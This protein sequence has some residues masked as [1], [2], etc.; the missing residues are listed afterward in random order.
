MGKKRNVTKKSNQNTRD[1]QNR[2]KTSKPKSSLGSR[3]L[4]I[5]SIGL[6]V[7]IWGALY[8]PVTDWFFGR[9]EGQ[10]SLGV[11]N[12]RVPENEPIYVFFSI[13]HNSHEAK[14]LVPVQLSVFNDFKKSEENVSLSLKYSKKNGRALLSER[15]MTHSGHRA[16]SEVSHEINSSKTYDY[17]LYQI[18]YL[19]IEGYVSVS[20]AAFT[21][22]VD[23]S[24]RFPVL[25]EIG[26]E[27]NIEA[28]SYSKG[29]KERT[30]DIRYRAVSVHSEAELEKWVK[31]YYGKSI[32]MELRRELTFCQYV[33]H[34]LF[35]DSITVYGFEPNFINIA[36]NGLYV[37]KED[38]KHYTGFTFN[39][40]LF[41]LLFDFAPAS[42]K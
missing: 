7:A 28:V 9:F 4:S 2:Q 39:P 30:W 21:S 29:D 40:Y 35:G 10:L 3:V 11:L 42:N 24:H 17:S 14:Y 18:D 19:P 13:P 32:A 37:P 23:Y 20:D 25:F 15:Y 36:N 6:L 26:Q 34:L 5:G 41:E 31:Q 16:K 33:E 1:T 27:L 8:A 22:K 12:A 38:V